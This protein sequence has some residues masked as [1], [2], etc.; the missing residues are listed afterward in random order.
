MRSESRR[1]VLWTLVGVHALLVLPAAA[2]R[3][4]PAQDAVTSGPDAG[5]GAGLLGLYLM[6]LGLPWSVFVC[7]FDTRW[8]L[9]GSPVGDLVVAGPALLNLALF[10]SWV[11][12]S[13]RHPVR[14]S[15]W[16]IEEVDEEERDHAG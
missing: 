8:A 11:W 1:V 10:A 15:T 7:L 13:G 9:F 6:A 3:L 4:G 2:L 16:V 5:L 14:E 12:W